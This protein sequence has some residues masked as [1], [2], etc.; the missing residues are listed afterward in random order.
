MTYIF[1]AFQS[2]Y[3]T[4]KHQRK[5]K[6]GRFPVIFMATTA[7]TSFILPDSMSIFSHIHLFL[8][9]EKRNLDS[10]QN[11][12]QIYGVPVKFAD[13]LFS[14]VCKFFWFLQESDS[15]LVLAY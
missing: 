7:T 13:N 14:V 15:F 10:N 6:K 8:L 1:V 5:E 11:E 9:L 12:Q 2:N 4:L 3:S